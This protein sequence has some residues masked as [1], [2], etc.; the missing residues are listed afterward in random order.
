MSFNI[1][2][3]GASG[4]GKTYLGS[5]LASKLNA[6]FL[7]TDDILW[8]WGDNIVPYSKATSEEEACKKME[9]Q[10]KNEGINIFSG[11][12]YPWSE[13]LNNDIDLLIIIETSDTIRKERIILR[14]EKMYGERYKEGGDMHSQFENYLQWAMSYNYSDD[15]L[16]SK[17]ETDK[18]KSKFKCP[19]L[20]IDGNLK[21]SEKIN[22]ILKKLKE[23]NI[24]CYNEPRRK[25]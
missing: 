19:I 13:S 1:E 20:I 22:I 3:T 12:F 21:I 6:T 4:A 15:K 11:M 16:G 18:W 24:T 14:E 5:A 23:I 9:K 17:K 10:M 25:L 2:I 7:D 8:E